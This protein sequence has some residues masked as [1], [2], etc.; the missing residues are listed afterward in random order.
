MPFLNFLFIHL[1]LAY[2]TYFVSPTHLVAMATWFYW[3]YCYFI[4]TAITSQFPI[5]L[6]SR[7]LEF[8]AIIPDIYE[9]LII[10]Y[11]SPF[12]NKTI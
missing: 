6:L 1:F 3:G 4:T 9:E 10:L 12:V 5:L 11:E 7:G 8:V 2:I